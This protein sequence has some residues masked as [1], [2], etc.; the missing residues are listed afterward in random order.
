MDKEIKCQ[1]CGK[2]PKII[3]S[4][5]YYIDRG[6]PFTFACQCLQVAGAT[7]EEAKEL[8]IDA[9]QG[10]SRAK[11][12]WSPFAEY[13]KEIMGSYGVA[14]KLRDLVLHLYN[15]NNPLDLA[16]LL[17]AADERHREIAIEL[18]KGYARRGEN[19]GYFM[20][21]AETIRDN[22]KG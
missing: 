6:W 12:R 14:A 16:G 2:I 4:K 18:I 8:W 9:R 7:P 3:D 19:D 22:N 15:S 5:Q 21:L 1:K 17:R 13:H 11:D 10:G 20:K